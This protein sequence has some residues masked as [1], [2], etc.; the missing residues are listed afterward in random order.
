[1]A[2]FDNN[3][4]SKGTGADSWLERQRDYYRKRK[5]DEDAKIAERLKEETATKAKEEEKSKGNIFQKA[6]G[7]TGNFIKDAA[8]DIKDTTV[9]AVTGLKDTV[10]GALATN[11]MERNTEK[12]N[13]NSK[14]WAAY[15]RTLPEGDEAAWNKPEVQ[16]KLKEFRYKA[17]LLRGDQINPEDIPANARGMQSDG[18]PKTAFT[19]GP[20]GKLELNQQQV[21]PYADYVP[22]SERAK[23]DMKEMNDLN[24]AKLG[25]QSAETFLNVATL[26]VGTGLKQAGKQGVKTAIKQGLKA[27]AKEAGKEAVETAIGTGAKTVA[28]NAAKDAAIGGAYGITTTLR[29]D[30]DGTKTGLDDYA[31]NIL[32]G[33]S[34]G[35]AAPVAGK[36]VTKLAG[37]TDK[38]AGRV[39]SNSVQTENESMRRALKQIGENGIVGTLNNAFSRAGR[40][41]VYAGSDL[42]QKTAAGRKLVDFK[43]DF[44]TKW[45]TNFHPLYKELKRSDF[46][47]KTTGAYVAAREAIGNSNRA[48]SYAQDFM[49]YNPNMQQLTGAIAARGKDLVKSREAFDEFAKV[50]SELDLAFAGKKEFGKGKMEELQKRM[51][52]FKEGGFDEEYKNLVG[53]YQD[54]NQFRLDNGLISQDDFDRFAEEGFDYVRQQRELPDWMLDKPSFGAAGGSKASITQSGA[55]Q[56]RN[57][58][59]SAE[60][61]SPLETAIRTAQQAHVEAYRN[62]A[63]KTVYGLL[64][65]AGDAKLVR[66]TDIVREKQALLTELKETRPVVNKMQKVVRSSQKQVNRLYTELNRLNTQGMNLRLKDTRDRSMPEFTPAGMGGDVPTSQAGQVVKVAQDDQTDLVKQLLAS[67]KRNPNSAK[68]KG[69]REDVIAEQA[70]VNA[71]TTPSMMGRADTKAFINSLVTADPAGL[72]KIRN[73]IESRDAKLTPLLDAVEVMNRDLHDM[74]AKRQGLYQ[75]AQGLKTSVDKSKMT[76][77]SFLDDGVENVVK[78]D[79]DIAAAVHN[80]DR[81]QQNVMTEVLRFS[82]NVFK[83]G[84][85]GA[86]V[87]FA[88]PN[89]V[90]DQVGSA[91]NSRSLMSTHNPVNFVH[92]MF[93]AMGKPLTAEDSDI[94]RGYLAGNKGQTAVNQYTKPASANKAVAALVGDAASKGSKLY[95]SLRHPKQMMRALFDATEGAVGLTENLTRIQN[96]RGSLKKASK[97]MD[98]T[99]ATRVANQAARENSVDFLEMGSYGRVVNTLIPYF[100]AS[101]QGSRIMFRNAAER[102]VSFAAKTAALVGVPLAAT[103]I[104]NTSS[105]ERKAIY[106]TIPEYVKETNFIVIGPNAKW[107]ET[108][109]KW[110]GVYLMKKPPGFKEF[111]EPVRKFIEYKADDPDGDLGEFFREEGGSIAADFGSSMGPIDFSDPNKFL[112]SVTPQIL[113]PTAEAILNKNFFQGTDIVPENLAEGGL[114]P[115][116]Q[117]YEQYSQLTSHIGAMFNV[118]PLK[119]DHWIKGTFGELGTNAQNTIDRATGAPEEAQGGRGL[120]ESIQRRFQGPPGGADTDAFYNTYNPAFTARKR[121]STQVTELVKAGRINE[122]KRRAE[123]YNATISERFRPF[124]Q[125]FQDSPNYDPEWDT[126]ISELLIKTSEGAFEA[127]R[128]QK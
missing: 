102:P 59:A 11:E 25:A 115:K 16:E 50:K 36:T 38:A 128:R 74:Y 42:A 75:T 44:M 122:A 66:S 92:S 117:K 64:D 76:S 78:V 48:L 67:V 21:D 65:E 10:Q 107:S 49:E 15:M 52:A 43:D 84:T 53:F 32:L 105:P 87:G 106:D 34:I 2:L 13:K 1:M 62:K 51:D 95:T 68:S 60:L 110:N 120:A 108:N 81:Q 9:G 30:P 14:E 82:N 29:N 89:F 103:T 45:V 58:Y 123:E 70:G 22:V 104:W 80:W 124:I 73:M 79:P 26:G 83:Y 109:K 12:M 4:F 47:G 111:A 19:V 101:I 93:M 5:E 72:K 86:N 24:A 33:A 85:T 126:K 116:D 18:K 96:Y 6:A 98:A 37:K 125:Q 112:S 90:A 77:I 88:L 23:R 127:R 31:R 46:E 54:L 99:D 3:W 27:G 118:S 7:A 8:I 94:L 28:K 119:V 97:T 61:L 71:E 63:A 113:K 17:K 55:I 20:G 41:V 114:E 91:I 40:K 121:A 56:K 69:L 100:N 39:V 35:A 57:K